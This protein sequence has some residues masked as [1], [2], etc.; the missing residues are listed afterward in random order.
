[1]ADPLPP[2]RPPTDLGATVG[3]VEVDGV[4]KEVTLA[5]RIVEVVGLGMFLT[6]AAAAV[7]FPVETLRAWRQRGAA[8]TRHL[9]NGD[10]TLTQL[11]AHERQCADL[12]IRWDRAEM[13][14]RRALLGVA[15]KV[16]K[17][18]L[19][20]TEVTKKVL[21]RETED[22]ETGRLVETTTK[23]VDVL[24]DGRMLSWMLERRWPEDY[25]RRRVEITGADGGAVQIED[26]GSAVAKLRAAI[27]E[28]REAKTEDAAANGNGT[29][30]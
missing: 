21:H 16:A 17:G 22:P 10:R 1:M 19:T 9:L 18:G 28:I 2:G 20:R 8:A 14:A 25:G 13:E 27:E 23:T 26:N 4:Q 30:V 12:S 15:D 7:G 24:P 29:H 6:D 5:D 11:S 3:W